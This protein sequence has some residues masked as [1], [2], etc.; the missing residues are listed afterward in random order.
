MS[1]T[2][3]RNFAKYLTHGTSQNRNT[4]KSG[5][6]RTTRSVNNINTV[7]EAL[8]GA[9]RNRTG[10]S[11]TTLNRITKL[12][13]EVASIHNELFPQDPARRLTFFTCLVERYAHFW[14]NL[15]IGDE[16]SFQMLCDELI[17][18]NLGN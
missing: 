2:I 4:E 3:L 18:I 6:R 5:R 17:S 1:R 8:R 14:P 9:R 7:H 11:K 12:D 13:P 15:V 10:V 16:A